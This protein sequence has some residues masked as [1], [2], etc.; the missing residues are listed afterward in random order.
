MLTNRDIVDLTGWRRMLHRF[1]DVSGDEAATAARVVQA[2]APLNPDRIVTGLGGHG[3]A[4]I[5]SAAEPGETLMFRAELDGLPIAEV[6]NPPHRSEVPGKGH[7][8]GHDGHMAILVGLARLISRQKPARGRVILMFQ[9]A[10]ETGAGAAAV[11][12]DPRYADLRPDWAYALHNMPG[13]SLGQAQL[14]PG[15]MLCA[16]QGLKVR[17]AGKTAHAAMPETGVSPALALAR[18]VPALMALGPAGPVGPGFRMVTITHARLGEPAFGIAP[19]AADLWVKLRALEDG[20]LSLLREAAAALIRTE[21]A[22]DGLIV[23]F[24]VEDDFAATENHPEATRH[25]VLALD[26]L[27]V[28]H[29]EG[30]LPWRASEDFGRFGTGGT[31]CAMVFLGAGSDHAALHNPDYDFPDDLIPIGASLFHRVMRDRLG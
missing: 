12:A 25:L 7:M 21:A 26:G 22:R 27:G 6:G 4:A 23:D 1:P 5:W 31:G 11:I 15:T 19:G 8:C 3:V 28:S 13:I 29:G 14:R 9:P 30:T 18:L 10:E 16:S 17:L 20:Q 24:A 2:L